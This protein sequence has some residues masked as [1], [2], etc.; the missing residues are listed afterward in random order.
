MKNLVDTDWLENNINNVKILDGSWHLPT[1]SRNAKDEYKK[2]HIKNSIFFDIDENSNKNSTLPHM[3]PEKKDWEKIISNLGIKNND[4]VVVYDDSEVYS[5]CRVWYSFMYFGHNENLV[6]VLD[7]GLRKWKK[8]KRLLTSKVNQIKKSNY[9]ANENKSMVVDKNQI[10]LN[11]EKKEF[12]LVD[13]RSNQRFLGLQPEIRNNLKSGN[14]QGSKNVPYAELI[15]ENFTFK[16][17]EELINLFKK[18]KVDISKKMVFTCGS[19]ITACVLGLTNSIISGK[20]PIIYDG[21]WSE[22][23]IK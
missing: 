21:S 6:S 5:A 12:E 7:G 20:K 10:N 16:T 11:I 23:G 9:T 17:K 4:H 13:A 14:I 2:N 18:N 8:E 19:G 15:N 22:Y 1:S 3:L